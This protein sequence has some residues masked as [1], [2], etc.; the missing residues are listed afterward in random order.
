MKQTLKRLQIDY[1]D[2]YLI[3]SP[4]AYSSSIIDQET[5][6]PVLF[7]TIPN[8]V[9]S[10][11]KNMGK[12]SNGLFY[13]IN[14]MNKENKFDLS[15]TWYQ[16]CQCVKLGLT[17]HVG[18]S[19]FNEKQLKL[20]MDTSDRF[21]KDLSQNSGDKKLNSNMN[22]DVGSSAQLYRCC[23]NQCE[24]HPYL[25]QT[26]LIEFCMK[27]N[28]IFQAYSPFGSPDRPRANI[29]LCPIMDEKVLNMARKYNKSVQQILLKFQ[30]QRKMA[31]VV[32]ATKLEHLKQNLDIFD[33][34]ITNQ[35]MNTLLGLHR[36]WRCVKLTR[37]KNHPEYP[38]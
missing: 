16:M 35:D 37:D 26:G 23:V 5:Q 28:I 30:I 15:D 36:S 8:N 29:K 3:H 21:I 22:D 27:N 20:I 33:F 25:T 11:D 2:L 38:F 18:V 4:I 34:E 19:N 12:S 31:L 7:P 10:K 14:E 6:L 24:C 13:A 17:K 1:L 32:K 9:N